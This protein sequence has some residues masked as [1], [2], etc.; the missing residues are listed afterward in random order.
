[1]LVVSYIATTP[2]GGGEQDMHPKK[3]KGLPTSQTKTEKTK[4]VNLLQRHQTEQSENAGLLPSEQ[5]KNVD[6][7]QNTFLTKKLKFR[8]QAGTSS[9]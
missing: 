6:L 3:N 2:S 5:T 8:I 4:N 7:L 1:M 9:T